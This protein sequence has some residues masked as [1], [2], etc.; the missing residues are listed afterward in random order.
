MNFDELRQISRNIPGWLADEEGELLYK[1]A[2]NCTKGEIVEIGSW[3]GKSIVWL[4]EGSRAGR[5]LKIHAIDPHEGY[6][7]MSTLKEFRQ[8]VEKAGVK[9][10]VIPIV[11]TSEQAAKNF[12]KPVGFIFIDG[13][14][15]YDDVKKDF[16]LW[17]P[18][19][20]D[21]GVM[22]FHDTLGYEG[23]RRLVNELVYKSRNFRKVR[24]VNNITYAVKTEENTQADR[25]RNRLMLLAKKLREMMIRKRG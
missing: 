4:A 20:I 1:L 16:E 14:H 21:G 18:K 13:S 7:G 3:K 9:N 11:K 24:L 17:F 15:E 12:G 8:N 23:P 2:K 5:G 22:A 19:L 6:D 10:M 25:V